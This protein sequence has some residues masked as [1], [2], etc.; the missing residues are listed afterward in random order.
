M[1]DKI[2]SATILE[3]AIPKPV[4]VRLRC[5]R[6]LASDNYFS[7][8][9]ISGPIA[10]SLKSM[11]VIFSILSPSNRNLTETGKSS[12]SL[13]TNMLLKLTL[14]KFGAF[15]KTF[16]LIHLHD[17]ESYVFQPKVI[18]VKFARSTSLKASMSSAGALS[19][20][21]AREGITKGI[22]FLS[23]YDFFF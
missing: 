12:L 14:C 5:L 13:V 17:S 19:Y 8:T 21:L 3:P 18:S 6:L 10:L 7:I 16:S 9:F 15:N 23:L 22:D 11:N 20:F 2:A 4:F 1:L